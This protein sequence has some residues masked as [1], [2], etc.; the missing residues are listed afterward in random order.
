MQQGELDVSGKDKY[1]I[2]LHGFPREVKVHFTDNAYIVPCNPHHLDYV[3][4]EIH[5]SNTVHS[6]FVLVISWEVTGVRQI[7][8][9]ASY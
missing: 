2:E 4:Y 3:E 9:T 6:G 7:K 5:A 8:W 1:K